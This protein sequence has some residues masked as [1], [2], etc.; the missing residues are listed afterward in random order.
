MLNGAGDIPIADISKLDNVIMNGIKI[1]LGMPRCQI[2]AAK[3]VPSITSAVTFSFKSFFS[4][5]FGPG[6]A[7][8]G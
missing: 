7:G 2:G 3:N 8:F 5:L 1:R 4:A 6:P